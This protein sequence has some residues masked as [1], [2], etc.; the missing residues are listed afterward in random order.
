MEKDEL[1]IRNCKGPFRVRNITCNPKNSR[2]V[3]EAQTSKS[4][5]AI[6]AL[7]TQIRVLDV[8]VL[9]RLLGDG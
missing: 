1:F 7:F 2:R 9:F 8:R 6:S 5:D 3:S 4:S